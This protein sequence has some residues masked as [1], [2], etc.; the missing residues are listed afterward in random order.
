MSY[1]PLLI[2]EIVRLHNTLATLTQLTQHESELLA[3]ADVDNLRDVLRRK[4][5]LIQLSSIQRESS[6]ALAA[7]ALNVT[8]TTHARLAGL[9]EEVAMS[10][11][12]DGNQEDHDML[13]S[14]WQAIICT[15]DELAKAQAR[16]ERFARQGMEWIEGCL[17]HLTQPAASHTNSTYT[18][19][20]KAR[21]RA[22][23]F[24]Q[25]QA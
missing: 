6:R 19:Q 14:E 13:T 15:L 20:G 22:A 4:A 17:E 5:E 9:I 11:H 2:A 8:L 12:K 1:A 10:L 24:L 3:T 21:A 23:S 25:R 7:S 16:S 18:R